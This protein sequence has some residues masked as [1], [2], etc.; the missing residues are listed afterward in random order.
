[1]R[2]RSRRAACQFGLNQVRVRSTRGR[3]RS[4]GSAVPTVRA[5]DSADH[6]PRPDVPAFHDSL[7]LF[8]SC[9]RALPDSPQSGRTTR[10]GPKN[11]CR[12]GNGREWGN[13]T[14]ESDVSASPAGCTDNLAFPADRGKSFPLR[15]REPERIIPR[16][17]EITAVRAWRRAAR[18]GSRQR[19][20]RHPRSRGLLRSAARRT[21]RHFCGRW[22]WL[23]LA[24][25]AV[26]SGLS[27]CL[28]EP[29]RLT[30]LTHRN[31]LYQPVEGLLPA[32]GRSS[33]KG[34]QP[35]TISSPSSKAKT[36]ND[37]DGR[38]RGAGRQDRRRRTRTVSIAS[39]TRAISALSATGLASTC[40][41]TRSGRSPRTFG[42]CSLL[43]EPLLIGLLDPLAGWRRLTLYEMT[44]KAA[45]MNGAFNLESKDN[46][47][48]RF[49]SSN[50]SH[51]PS[52]SRSSIWTIR[53]STSRRG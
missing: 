39:T 42:R 41:P 18:H 48:Q 25:V 8:R 21:R 34:V 36:R 9:P 40:R 24:A 37:G 2:S 14:E 28:H 32:A 27:V 23:V 12:R 43:L 45:L 30:Y 52:R 6:Q 20:P 53:R 51:R 46:L 38:A 17:T 11:R 49:R 7:S 13:R 50:S 1:M 3:S 31:D 10:N 35:M 22:P 19:L 15:D 47:D 44:D 16:S 26:S 5:A 33:S 29:K 4:P